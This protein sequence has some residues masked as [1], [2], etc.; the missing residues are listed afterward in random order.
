[1]TPLQSRITLMID[2][3]AG[4]LLCVYLWRAGDPL[5]WVVL[6][7]LVVLVYGVGYFLH[8]RLEREWKARQERPWTP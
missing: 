1:M 4:I 6:A 7:G 3:W 2:E 8:F 5:F